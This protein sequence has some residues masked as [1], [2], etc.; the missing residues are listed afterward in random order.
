MEEQITLEKSV[1]D[2]SREH[3]TGLGVSLFTAIETVSLLAGNSAWDFIVVGDNGVLI[4]VQGCRNAIWN[5]LHDFIKIN[6]YE[7]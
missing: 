6:N 3:L 5:P 7:Q 2:I 4:T 1:F